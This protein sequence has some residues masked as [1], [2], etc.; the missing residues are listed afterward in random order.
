MKINELHYLHQEVRKRKNKSKKL[1]ETILLIKA[2]L[3]EREKYLRS[4]LQ[5]KADFWQRSSQQK[6][7]GRLIQEEREKIQVMSGLRKGITT[8][9]N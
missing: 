9:F 5:T 6:K 7:Y 2:L 8:D 1:K 4:L 3:D